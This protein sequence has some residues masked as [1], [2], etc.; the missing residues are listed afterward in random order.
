MYG[1][2]CMSHA[3]YIA[4]ILEWSSACEVGAGKRWM[5][6]TSPLPSY[7]ARLLLQRILHF[8]YYNLVSIENLY[9]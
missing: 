8:L 1:V 5:G 4:Q 7:L 9:I 6:C 3:Y 2:D